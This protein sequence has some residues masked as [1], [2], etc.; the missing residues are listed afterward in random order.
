MIENAFVKKVVQGILR[1]RKQSLLD[2]SIMHPYREW[3][4][5]LAAG[6]CVL[7]I[8]VAWGVSTY[9]QFSNV[10]V[11]GDSKE[12]ENLV[13]RESLVETAL[14]D[15]SQRKDEYETL[16][17]ALLNRQRVVDEVVLPPVVEV[18]TSSNDI[19]PEVEPEVLEPIPEESA[20][21]AESEIGTAEL[22]I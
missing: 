22:A 4:S 10:S 19:E 7:S 18:A 2:R 20:V 15:F 13:Y 5:G 12:E 11:G 3:F 6:L 1:N 17:Q 14:T 16:K 21:S 9:V 8:C